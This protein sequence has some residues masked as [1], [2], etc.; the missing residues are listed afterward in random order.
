MNGMAIA[1]M[2]LGIVWVYWIGSILALIFGFIA[3]RQIR[4]RNENG[5]GLAIAGV[6]LGS[7][8]AVFLIL[9]IIGIVLA[10]N[11]WNTTYQ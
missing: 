9:F 6:V 3:L 2:V 4:E 10:S 5:R 1:S 7:V 11:R 8:G